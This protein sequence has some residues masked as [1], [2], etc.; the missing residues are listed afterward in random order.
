MFRRTDR[1]NTEPPTLPA[2]AHC[3]LRV[4]LGAVDWPV[5]RHQV[6]FIG[7]PVHEERHS[8]KLHVDHVI[9]PLLVADL[10]GGQRRCGAVN[11]Q[12]LCYVSTYH[13]CKWERILS[14]HI[15]ENRTA[16]KI[17]LVA[18]S[19]FWSLI[20]VRSISPWRIMFTGMRLWRWCLLQAQSRDRKANPWSL[21]ASL[22][23]VTAE[24]Q[25]PLLISGSSES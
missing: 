21:L 17:H 13:A 7:H 16:L 14:L 18:T 23:S 12:F 1:A 20:W 3:K 4:D 8:R 10:Q 6:G 11:L 24:Q 25:I 5:I 9:V 22:P 19:H 2:G 15:F